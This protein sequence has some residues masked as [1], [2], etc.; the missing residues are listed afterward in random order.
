MSLKID[1]LEDAQ[2]FHVYHVMLKK[3]LRFLESGGLHWMFQAGNQRV[4][5][6]D[7]IDG[8][9]GLRYVG[10]DDDCVYIGLITSP[11][12]DAHVNQER[13]GFTVTTDDTA[14]IH[15]AGVAAAKDF[16]SKYIER[17]RRRQIETTD[18]LILANLACTRFG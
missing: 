2:E 8:Q 1:L 15:S 13:T 11:F 17:I 3:Q 16:L 5:K 14:Q 12:L 7:A 4:A 18:R 6:Q 9:I 10:D